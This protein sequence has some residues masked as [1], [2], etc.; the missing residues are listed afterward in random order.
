[1]V[2]ALAASGSDPSAARGAGAARIF[3]CKNGIASARR[4]TARFKS[5]TR[6]LAKKRRAWSVCRWWAV[7]EGRSIAA[8]GGTA[9]RRRLDTRC[10]VAL[11]AVARST[12]AMPRSSP[13]P[14]RA[15]RWRLPR[16]SGTATIIKHRRQKH[17]LRRASAVH[18]LDIIVVQRG[19]RHHLHVLWSSHPHPTFK[20][21]GMGGVDI[22]Y[23]RYFFDLVFD[24]RRHTCN[25]RLCT[26]T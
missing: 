14:P 21:S 8:A 20:E 17:L 16:R 18:H 24:E 11:D 26:G 10:T 12:R 15:L 7:D 4:A 3:C 23:A 5:C 2:P 19:H 9:R 13:S 22:N 6:W 1:M 25:R